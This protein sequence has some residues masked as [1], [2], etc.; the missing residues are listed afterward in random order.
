MSADLRQAV[1]Q[2]MERLRTSLE[3]R[4]VGLAEKM[5]REA[6]EELTAA[7][8]Q[9]EAELVQ[10][11]ERLA[12]LE[13]ANGQAMLGRRLAEARLDEEVKRRIARSLHPPG[14]RRCLPNLQTR[15]SSPP[16]G[17]PSASNCKPPVRSWLTESPVCWLISLL[18][19]RKSSHRRHCS[20]IESCVS[21]CEPA[22]AHAPPKAASY[23]RSSSRLTQRWVRNTAPECCSPTWI[24]QR[25]THWSPDKAFPGWPRHLPHTDSSAER[26]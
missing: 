10:T 20:P 16:A 26:A 24:E 17:R 1:Q 25:S 19:A 15:P 11:R 4:V 23:G 21:C 22:R 12:A 14:R 9:L 3:E 6:V 13:R 2:E 8:D 5:A 7:R 18:S